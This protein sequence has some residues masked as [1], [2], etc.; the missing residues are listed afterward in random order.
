MKKAVIFAYCGLALIALIVAF[1]CADSPESTISGGDN[2]RP[3]LLRVYPADGTVGVATTNTVG[4]KFNTSMDTLSVMA[5]FHFS[6]GSN[7]QLWMDSVD[8]QG[9]MGHMTQVDMNRMMQLM[10]SIEIRGTFQWNQNLDSCQFIPDSA[11]MGDTEHM[12]FIYGQMMSGNGMMMDMG[13]SGMMDSDI[14]F[15]YHFTTAP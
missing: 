8:N 4:L 5:G 2:F 3:V 6:G 11:M 7:M 9:G 13:R 1:G 14:G 12:I 10:D 15:T